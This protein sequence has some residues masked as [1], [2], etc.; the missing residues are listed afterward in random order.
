MRRAAPPPLI[1]ASCFKFE[2]W[3]GLDVEAADFVVDDGEDDDK[4][5]IS[6]D[7]VELFHLC[8]SLFPGREAQ[9]ASITGRGAG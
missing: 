4:P 6:D 2:V 5:E 8:M 1:K 3:L 9:S 7:E